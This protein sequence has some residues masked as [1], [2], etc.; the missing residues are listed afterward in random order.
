LRFSYVE[1]VTKERFLRAVTSDPPEFVGAEDNRVLEEKLKAEKAALKTR[2]EE[3]AGLIR[4]LEE[5]GRSLAAS[6]YCIREACGIV[7]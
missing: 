7:G 3:V 5:Q 6:E 4:E 1:Q 2:K